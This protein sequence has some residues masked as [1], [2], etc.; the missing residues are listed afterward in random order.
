M[1]TTIT[2]FLADERGLGG[3]E[4]AVAAFIGALFAM[5]SAHNLELQ[6]AK[7]FGTVGK[8]LLDIL[9]SDGRPAPAVCS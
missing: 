3:T 7:T 9:G 4:Y 5:G 2:A 1:L 6:M 8:S